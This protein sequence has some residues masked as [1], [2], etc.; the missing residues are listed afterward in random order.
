ML[1]VGELRPSRGGGRGVRSR[2]RGARRER[3]QRDDRQQ[4]DFMRSSSRDVRA[5]PRTRAAP[6][7]RPGREAREERDRAA[8]LR[9]LAAVQHDRLLDGLRAAVVQERAVEAQPDQRRRAPSRELASPST[10]Q[11]VGE[12]VAHVVQQH[13]GVDGRVDVGELRLSGSRRACAGR[14]RDRRRTRAARRAPRRR[15]GS[16]PARDGMSRTYVA[17]ALTL[18][19]STSTPGLASSVSPSG[20]GNSAG[21]SGLVMPMS[22]WNASAVKSSRVAMRALRPK[23]PITPS[24]FRCAWKR[25]RGWAPR[26]RSR[27]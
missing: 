2:R 27:G 16:A 3:R 8:R 19:R 21:R 10:R 23:R 18:S 5:L 20:L 17:R 11:A 26:R 25:G 13:V 7:A 9:A 15:V 14:A 1:G 24:P 6:R 4:I 22:P 12:S